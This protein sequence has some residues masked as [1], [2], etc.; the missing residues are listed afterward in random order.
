MFEY[1]SFMT[2]IRILTKSRIPLLTDYRVL[3]LLFP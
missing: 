3:N 2:E 1:L